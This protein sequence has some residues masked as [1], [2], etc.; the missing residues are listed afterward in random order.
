LRDVVT[1]DKDDA[2]AEKGAR[3]HNRPKRW[4]KIDGKEKMDGIRERK[5]ETYYAK[6]L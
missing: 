4:N 2:H 3:L 5:K 1:G 6:S